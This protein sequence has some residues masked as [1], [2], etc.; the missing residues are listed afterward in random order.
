MKLISC[1]KIRDAL[2]FQHG[3]D[4]RERVWLFDKHFC[5]LSKVEFEELLKE[6]NP[7]NAVFKE[8]L[9]DCEDFAHVLSAMVKLTALK[10]RYERGIAFGEITIRHLVT[11]NIH[12][13]NFLVTEDLEAL[14]FEPQGRLF[15]NGKNYKPFYARI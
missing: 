9:F 2:Q 4:G 8:E 7:I 14:Y 13:L 10:K 3:L 15:V 12:S 6:L 11:N 1:Q 5:G